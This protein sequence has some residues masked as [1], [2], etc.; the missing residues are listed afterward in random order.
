MTCK[1]EYLLDGSLCTDWKNLKFY[2]V[3]FFLRFQ[4]ICCLDFFIFLLDYIT[5]FILLSE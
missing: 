3:P 1:E 5:V 2:S 4:A